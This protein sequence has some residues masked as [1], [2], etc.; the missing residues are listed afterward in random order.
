MGSE[1]NASVHGFLV[2]NSL[3]TLSVSTLVSLCA[4]KSAS[5]ESLSAR[6]VEHKYVL[7]LRMQL[8]D[9]SKI[10]VDTSTALSK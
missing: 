1:F 3:T 10:A 5:P 4:C 8:N 7:T 6:I 9:H 2:Q